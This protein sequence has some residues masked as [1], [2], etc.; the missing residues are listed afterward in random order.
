MTRLLI[1]K[2]HVK[3]IVSIG[4]HPDIRFN[5]QLNCFHF[6]GSW[7]PWKDVAESS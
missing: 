3:M 1:E 6:P 2:D 7:A 5:P 4:S